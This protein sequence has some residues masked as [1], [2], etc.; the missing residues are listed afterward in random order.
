M[1]LCGIQSFYLSHTGVIGVVKCK[2]VCPP[3]PRKK[4]ELLRNNNKKRNKNIFFKKCCRQTDS[5]CATM[6]VAEEVRFLNVLNC[7]Q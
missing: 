5:G 7:V 1:T 2:V 3:G 4:K 6:D